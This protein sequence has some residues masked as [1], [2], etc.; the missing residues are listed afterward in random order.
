MMND[1]NTDNTNDDN[2]IKNILM[3]T[4]H[5]I[6]QDFSIVNVVITYRNFLMPVILPW[7]VRV[8][9]TCTKPQQAQ[10]SLNW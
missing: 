2:E 9:L 1:N 5:C 10:D 6:F 3:I 8:K 7:W 4:L